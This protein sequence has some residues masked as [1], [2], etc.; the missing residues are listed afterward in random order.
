MRVSLSPLELLHPDGVAERAVVVGSGC[1]ER[2]L[3]ARLAERGERWDLAVVAPNRNELRTRGWLEG[4]VRSVASGLAAD[5]LAYVLVPREARSRAIRTLERNGLTTVPGFVHLPDWAETRHLVPLSRGPAAYAFSSLIPV[6]ASRRRL[7]LTALQ[8][9]YGPHVLRR[10][11]PGVGLAARPLAGRPLAEWLFRIDSAC[12]AAQLPVVSAS[13]QSGA[14][15]FVLHRFLSNEDRPSGVAKVRAGGR[16]ATSVINEAE[17]LK[18]LA[19]SARGAGAEAPEPLVVDAREGRSLLFETPVRGRSA[20]VLLADAP[21]RL[22]EVHRR[23]ARWLE[24]WSRSR[25]APQQLS[26]ERLAEEIL[27]P[28]RQLAS[29]L[30][31][32]RDYL[33]WLAA[34]CDELGDTSIPHVPTHNDLTMSNVFLDEAGSLGVVDWEAGREDGLPLVDFFYA[35]ADA[36]AATSRYRDRT[37]AV[38]ECFSD[39]GRDAASVRLLEASLARAI[40]LPAAAAELCFHACW[41]H[42]AANEHRRGGSDRP[43]LE[44]LRWVAQPGRRAEPS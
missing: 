3:P 41:L 16:S 8:L 28:A 17:I 40:E 30:P 13:W 37:K 22:S 11:A 36:A 12:G 33:S 42:H 20:A 2:L 35:T 6:R 1:P 24:G 43:F 27:G 18:R 44:I 32:G 19:A 14:G 4:T 5:G 31:G 39:G 25:A 23:V 29:L 10:F 7:M 21:E 26:Q 38:V 15:S 9:P 34:S